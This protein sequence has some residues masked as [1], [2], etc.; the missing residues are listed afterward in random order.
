M[1]TQIAE[2]ENYI[3]HVLFINNADYNRAKSRYSRFVEKIAPLAAEL[4]KIGLSPLTIESL[5]QIAIGKFDQ[6]TAE[7][8]EKAEADI[9]NVG[10]VFRPI[11][12]DS[13]KKGLRSITE[14]LGRFQLVLSNSQ[15]E[16][17]CPVIKGV[18][19]YSPEF[20]AEVKERFTNRIQTEAGSDFYKKFLIAQAAVK[21]LC[22]MGGRPELHFDWDREL[23]L[24]LSA[25]AE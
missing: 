7:F 20:D 25:V 10:F 24:S 15:D 13:I 5:N 14:F 21:E 2:E 6:F 11:G 23:G 12:Q 4:T 22:D 8:K 19:A 3:G 16:L 18:P 17:D 1:K 9:S